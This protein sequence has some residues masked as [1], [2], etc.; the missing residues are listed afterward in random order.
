MNATRVDWLREAERIGRRLDLLGAISEGEGA[1][2]RP[3]F[4][5]SLC[6]AMEETARWMEEAGLRPAVDAFGNLRGWGVR[7]N[8]EPV[9]LIGSHLDTVPGGGR[10]DGALGI[11]LGISAAEI[12]QDRAG[13]LPFALDILAFQEE[14]GARFRSGCLGSRAFLGLLEEKDWNLEDSSGIS[15]RE[16]HDSFSIQ[17]W[18]RMEP[19]PREKLLGYCEAHIEQGPQLEALGVP[20]G[21]ALGIVAQERLLLSFLGE[22]GHAGCVP[23]SARRDALCA[24]AAFVAFVEEASRR[25][26]GAVATVGELHCLPGAVNVIPKRVDLSV[27]LRHPEEAALD[28]L[29][30]ALLE[31]AEEIGRDRGIEVG[32]RRTQRLPPVR[33]DPDWQ[34]RLSSVITTIQGKAPRLWSG[35]GHDAGVFGRLV[36]MV[37]LFVRCRGGVSHDPAELVS[38][39]DTARALEALVGFVEGFLP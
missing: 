36:P 26:P 21:V 3:P 27:D 20:L 25:E 2:N 1:L 35:A 17:G 14:E 23:M 18:P 13:S 16:A 29:S 34:D 9:L 4:T 37:L 22:G 30:Q 11:L 19:D 38:P 8:Q 15:L 39:S 6:R 32:W 24:A 28:R 31:R 12:L 10:F 7:E 5:R 33:S